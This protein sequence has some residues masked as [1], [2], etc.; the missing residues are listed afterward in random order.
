M[1]DVNKHIEDIIIEMEK[2]GA[3]CT[4]GRHHL[5]FIKLIDGR[6]AEI[7]VEINTDDTEWLNDEA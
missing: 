3:A 1:E 6:R 7:T 4:S 5:G 2:F